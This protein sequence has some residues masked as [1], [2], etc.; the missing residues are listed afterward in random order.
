MEGVRL[1]PVCEDRRPPASKLASATIGHQE[2]VYTPPKP[3]HESF[4][5]TDDQVVSR[6]CSSP[7]A[8]KI[9][10]VASLLTAGIS[11]V[12]AHTPATSSTSRQ[13]VT[14]SPPA[15]AGLGVFG[16]TLASTR[17]D[18]APCVPDHEERPGL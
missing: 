18:G 9:G 16:S 7:A 3:Q 2:G 4:V 10:R 14:E 6:F 12:E 13:W 1:C 5:V 8:N 11:E 17:A 15:A